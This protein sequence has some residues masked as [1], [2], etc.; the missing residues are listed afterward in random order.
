MKAVVWHGKRDV[1]VETVP[2]PRSSSRPMRSYGSR[3]AAV[4]LR[5]PPVRGVGAVHDGGRHPRPRA[6]GHRRGGR[7]GGHRHRR[8]RP[9]R[10]PVQHLVRALL[11]VRPR[12]A[13]A[14]RDDAGPRARHRRRHCSAT[15]S[16]TARSRAGRPSCCGCPRPSTARSRCPR[17][18]RTIASCTCPTSCRR[19][20]RRSSTPTCPRRE[21]R[22]ARSRPDRRHGLPHR[23]HRGHR[24]RHRGRSRPRTPR[25][26][27]A[28]RRRRCSTS[29]SSSDDELVASGARAHR[30]TR[31]RRRHR[32]RRHG[33][34][35]LPGRQAR[36]SSSIGMMPDASAEK[37]MEK[38][39]ASTGSPPC[40][41]PS[42]S[43]GAAARSR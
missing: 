32:C 13:V 19:R 14:V 16:C 3:R 35:R 4:R 43:S 8:G 17:D 36:H 42:R 39:P 20:G 25:A 40:S 41:R 15:P 22:R 29:T 23:P 21:R 5:P 30:R 31:P 9:G 24:A 38:R 2:D 26:G 18:R 27:A 33:G 11:H 10:H 37:L 12:A 28:P 34:P 6:D 7:R 1:R